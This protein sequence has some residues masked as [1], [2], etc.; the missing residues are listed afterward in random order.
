M[1]PLFRL[2]VRRGAGAVLALC[3]GTGLG[4]GTVLSGAGGLGSPVLARLARRLLVAGTVLAAGGAV[5]GLAALPVFRPAS[6]CPGPSRVQVSGMPGLPPLTRVAVPA[7]S[8][9]SSAS[10]AAA[11]PVPAA[12]AMTAT[13]LPG[14]APARRERPLP[15]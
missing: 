9:A 8:I 3:V 5:T 13:A 1:G 6:S 15:G 7:F 10:R 4:G 2:G 12:S 14:L 11:L